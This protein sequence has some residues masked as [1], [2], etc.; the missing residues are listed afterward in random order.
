MASIMSKN[1]G[2]REVV[3]EAV[4]NKAPFGHVEDSLLPSTSH[5]RQPR[6]S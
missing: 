4:G 3:V 6:A 1:Y 5:K 2:T